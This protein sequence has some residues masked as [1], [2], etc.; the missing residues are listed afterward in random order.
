MI[1]LKDCEWAL[2]LY[3]VANEPYFKMSELRDN[4]EEFYDS[5]VEY[6]LDRLDPHA[7]AVFS[8]SHEHIGWA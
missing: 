5:W 7:Y 6:Q 1:E 3:R 4:T 2:G 8:L